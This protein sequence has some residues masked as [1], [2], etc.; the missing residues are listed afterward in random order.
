MLQNRWIVGLIVAVFTVLTLAA[1][2]DAHGPQAVTLTYDK[3]QSTLEVKIT[4]KTPR[5][6]HYIDQVILQRNGQEIGV[7]TYKSQ[8]D[9]DTFTYSYKVEAAPGDVLEAKAVCNIVGSKTGR[10]SVGR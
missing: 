10:L 3:A 1:G 4:H 7:Y 9:P 6:S 2:A 5:T 8:P